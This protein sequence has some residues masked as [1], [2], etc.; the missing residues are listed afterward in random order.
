MEENKK[1]I[2]NSDFVIID[3]T[4]RLSIADSEK[5]KEMYEYIKNSKGLMYE[6]SNQLPKY[7]IKDVVINSD[8][9]NFKEDGTIIDT[10]P[11]PFD[12]KEFEKRIKDTINKL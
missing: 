12:V 3:T 10:I 9:S 11:K 4:D 1:Y 7:S 6:L 8:F 5:L 2:E